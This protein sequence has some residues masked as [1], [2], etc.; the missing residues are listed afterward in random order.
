MD[1]NRK[2]EVAEIM[3]QGGFD[4]V[5]VDLEH[6][7]IDVS[8]LPNLFRSLELGGTLPLV[9]LSKPDV[10]ELRRSLDAGA[11]GVIIPMVEDAEVLDEIIRYRQ[12]GFGRCSRG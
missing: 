11:G 5:A 2:C 1:A 9:R 3:G 6:G 7:S 4:W 10:F 12:N 8:Q